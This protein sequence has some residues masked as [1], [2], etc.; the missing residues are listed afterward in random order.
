MAIVHSKNNTRKYSHN[1]SYR[2]R[3]MVYYSIKFTHLNDNYTLLQKSVGRYY[4]FNDTL[5]PN[6]N[7]LIQFFKQNNTNNIV[8]DRYIELFNTLL[9]DY[10][11]KPSK[12]HFIQ[13]LL[14]YAEWVNITINEELESHIT[15]IIQNIETK[16]YSIQL[17][18]KFTNFMTLRNMK[19][20]YFKYMGRSGDIHIFNKTKIYKNIRMYKKLLEL[21]KFSIND[22]IPSLLN[23]FY[24]L[25][26]I[27]KI[28]PRLVNIITNKIKFIESGSFGS[29]FKIETK[30]EAIKVIDVSKVSSL[31]EVIAL[32][33][34]EVYTYYRITTLACNRN[35]FCNFINAYYDN[36]IHKIYVLMEYCG[37]DLFTVLDST[38]V[39]HIP[40]KWFLN[41]A[42]GIKC[43]HD[44]NYVH[45]DIKPEN[46][47]IENVKYL[48]QLPQNIS[49][50]RNRSNESS[51]RNRSNESSGRNRSN[52]SSGR[53]RSNESSGRN[54]SNESSGRNRSN[55][56]N[57][58]SRI[59]RSSLYIPRETIAKLI[60]FGLS[61]EISTISSL[62]PLHGTDGYRAPELYSQTSIDYKKCDIYSLG[63][64]IGI[65][66]YLKTYNPPI[67]TSINDMVGRDEFKYLLFKLNLHDMID[68]NPDVRPNIDEVIQRLHKITNRL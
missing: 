51:G 55:E 32:I 35:L 14:R 50:G 67:E 16:P 2:K 18:T 68:V 49:S 13:L 41:I 8:N 10:I 60:D 29:V 65:C 23:S 12:F 46:I 40:I 33:K 47:I 34:R 63:I 64:T 22:D 20:L 44:N 53:N 19:Y 28:E 27:Y 43:M 61:Y 7:G 9:K 42:Y 62:H 15:N 48:D 45:F 4:K 25:L 37:V 26:P 21:Y 59:S 30:P 56:S 11:T 17:L 52:E 5:F 54:I 39:K 31:N 1:R 36:N 57:Q 66:L 24:G 58:R 38:N 6:L 3:D